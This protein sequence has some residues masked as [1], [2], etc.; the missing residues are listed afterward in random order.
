[1]FSPLNCILHF[2]TPK[3]TA[4]CPASVIWN[5]LIMFSAEMP[6]LLLCNM[7]YSPWKQ[8]DGSDSKAGQRHCVE[9]HQLEHMKRERGTTRFQPPPCHHP[10]IR[11]AIG[12]TQCD[13]Y[14]CFWRGVLINSHERG[15]SIQLASKDA[16]HWAGLLFS[17]VHKT[18]SIEKRGCFSRCVQA[19]MMPLDWCP[20][21]V[22]K[23]SVV[24]EVI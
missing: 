1:M 18:L 9:I 16:L 3:A 8:T 15:P 4:F 17:P 11:G 19:Q 14:V 7:W 20:L 6:N 12:R 2:E 21:W 22:K 13:L 23:A 10:R 24:L 5:I